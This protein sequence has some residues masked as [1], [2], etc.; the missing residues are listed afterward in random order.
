M[1]GERG[2]RDG[3]VLMG[4]GLRCDGWSSLLHPPCAMRAVLAIGAAPV[5]RFCGEHCTVLKTQPEVGMADRGGCSKL[6]R[7]GYGYAC[8]EADFGWRLEK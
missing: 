5:H 6:V 4:A 3:N 2:A 8:R 7:R 1:G